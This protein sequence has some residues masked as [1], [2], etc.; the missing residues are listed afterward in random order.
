MQAKHVQA[1]APQATRDARQM[2]LRL[3]R[4]LQVPEAVDHVERDIDFA[5]ESKVRHVRDERRFGKA[6]PL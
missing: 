5:R 4:R 1:A 6:L 2:I 3:L